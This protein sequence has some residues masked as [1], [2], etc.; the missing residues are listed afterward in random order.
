MTVI[1][2]AGQRECFHQHMKEKQTLDF[3]YQ[4]LEGGDLD[5][6]FILRSPTNKALAT[7]ARKEDAIHTF[8]LKETGEYLFC[9]D[10]S[11]SRMAR[12]TVFFD[13]IVD[14]EDEVEDPNEAEKQAYFDAYAAQ[15]MYEIRIEEI[16]D[17]L[18]N[19]KEN[20]FKSQSHQRTWRNI[21]FRD[22]Y[23]AERNYER[24]GFWSVVSSLVMIGTFIIQVLMIRSLFGNTNKVVT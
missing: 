23:I 7:D 21:E 15:E 13:L 1:V 4:V 19:V 6:N 9:F 18:S 22:R 10:N 24:V 3:E 17:V 5:I 12:K 8:E 16:E 2:P 14:S 20:L 11:F